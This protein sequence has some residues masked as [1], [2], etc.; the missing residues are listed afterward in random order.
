MA[1]TVSKDEFEWREW[2]LGEGRFKQYGPHDPAHRPDVPAKIPAAWW[3]RLEAFLTRRHD[4]AESGQHGDDTPVKPPPA[5]VPERVS[6]HFRT[7]EFDCHDGRKVPAVAIPALSRLA[8]E[9]LEPLRT[10]FGPAHVLS[11]YRPRDYNAKI[12]GAKFSQHIYEL[13]PNSVAADMVFASGNPQAWARA[14]DRLGAGGVGLY[15][16]SGFVHVDNRSGRARWTG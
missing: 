6:P 9:L 1:T 5:K 3:R 10:S 2:W 16:S 8:R 4:Y 7:A 13:T 15:V 12:G 14:A 11:G